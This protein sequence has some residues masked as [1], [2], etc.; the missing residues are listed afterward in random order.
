MTALARP[1]MGDRYTHAHRAE[2]AATRW[3]RAISRGRD[4]EAMVAEMRYR[5]ATKLC[6]RA[7]EAERTRR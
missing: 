3:L 4:R 2:A 1:G 5:L 7:G 6:A